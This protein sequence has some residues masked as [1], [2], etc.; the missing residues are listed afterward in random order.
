MKTIALTQGFFAKVDDE[1]FEYLSSFKWSVARRRQ[2]NYAQRY[3]KV[4]GK[5]TVVLMHREIIGSAGMGKEIDHKNGDGLDNQRANLRPSTRSQNAANTHARS[6]CGFKGVSRNKTR[7]MARLSTGT[8]CHQHLG[9]FDTPEE[10]ARAYDTAAQGR[11][12]EFAR[13]N[14]K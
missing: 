4:N 12:G 9:T 13:L 14:F 5:K 1:D 2:K 6:V 7:F 11:F 3:A 8:G 10:A